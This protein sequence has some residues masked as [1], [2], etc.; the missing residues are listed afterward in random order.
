MTS[1]ERFLRGFV[2][3]RENETPPMSWKR[4][5]ILKADK[6]LMRTIQT[7]MVG[8]S[9][10][11][12][13]RENGCEKIPP[14]CY[15]FKPNLTPT[16][17]CRFKPA[18]SFPFTPYTERRTAAACNSAPRSLESQE[19]IILKPIS[20]SLLGFLFFFAFPVKHSEGIN[21]SRR[22]HDLSPQSVSSLGDFSP[23]QTPNRW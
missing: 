18:V 19:S 10:P 3:N 14:F 16:L 23:F 22:S 20:L 6:A 21:Q 9:C 11:D 15:R 8:L 5:T 2:P 4:C 13:N 17:S 1:I 7:R 12:A